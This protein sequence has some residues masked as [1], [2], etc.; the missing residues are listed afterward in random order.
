MG[1]VNDAL[2]L[3]VV[4]FNL[5]VGAA[6]SVGAVPEPGTWAMMLMGFGAIGFGMRRKNNASL[7]LRQLA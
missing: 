1:A 5:P 6:P 2:S 7:R 4:Q 3:N